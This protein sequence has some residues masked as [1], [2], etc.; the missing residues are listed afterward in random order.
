MIKNE[1][2]II[3][4]DENYPCSECGEDSGRG[5]DDGIC[6]ECLDE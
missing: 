2:D 3:P 1:K 5:Y 4:E 6:A